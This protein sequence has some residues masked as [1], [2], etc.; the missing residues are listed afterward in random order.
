MN[1]HCSRD[2]VE[3]GGGGVKALRSDMIREFLPKIIYDVKSMV[4]MID[5]YPSVDSLLS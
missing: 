2:I 5:T 1:V 4:S 3:G